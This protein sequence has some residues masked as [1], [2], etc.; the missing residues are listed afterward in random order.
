MNRLLTLIVAGSV[1]LTM[2]GASWPADQ[3]PAQGSQNPPAQHPQTGPSDKPASEASDQSN[4]PGERGA[5]GTY[6]AS[7][8]RCETISDTAKRQECIDKVRKAYGHM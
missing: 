1:A 6:S 7:I 8:R 2:S 5:E 3:A 4:R